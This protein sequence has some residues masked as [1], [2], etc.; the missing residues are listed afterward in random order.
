[1]IDIALIREKPDWVKEQLQRLNAPDVI[2]RIDAI[3]SLDQQ[4]R[5]LLTEVEAIKANRN[6]IS[7]Q[8]G[9]FRGNKKLNP[10]EVIGGATT[11]SRG[12]P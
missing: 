1:M 7:K 11:S 9:R 6:V 3:I 2:E 8:M 5:Q 4:R 10:A 12:T